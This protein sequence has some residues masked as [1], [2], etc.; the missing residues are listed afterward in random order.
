M[1]P[2]NFLRNLDSRAP[3]LNGLNPLSTLSGL[4]LELPI[5]TDVRG[6]G[7]IAREEAALESHIVQKIASGELE[8]LKPNSGKAI[9]IGEHQICVA[10]HDDTESGYRIWEWHGHLLMF[11]DDEGYSPEYI[12]GNHFQSLDKKLDDDVNGLLD[13]VNDDEDVD[14][15]HAIC[16]GVAALGLGSIIPLDDSKKHQQLPRHSKVLHRTGNTDTTLLK[17]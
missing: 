8:S 6:K 2:Y 13:N 12:Y 9:S 17:K 4:N 7:K 3:F 10:F 5:P 15:R 1:D 11:D 16:N 14:G